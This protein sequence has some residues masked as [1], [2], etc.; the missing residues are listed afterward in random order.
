MKHSNFHMIT[1]TICSY[2]PFQITINAVSQTKIHEII[3]ILLLPFQITINAVSHT[4]IQEIILGC[5][6]ILLLQN[7]CHHDSMK[8]TAAAE[9][10]IL[11]Q[12]RSNEVEF[13]VS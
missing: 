11:G 6:M 12:I 8:G 7:V 5:K 1:F 13:P 4:K 10:T 3:L 2:L 9:E